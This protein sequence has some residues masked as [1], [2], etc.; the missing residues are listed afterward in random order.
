MLLIIKLMM[1][2]LFELLITNNELTHLIDQTLFPEHLLGT[3]IHFMFINKYKYRKWN[4]SSTE[5]VE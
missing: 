5:S 3:Q 2:Q 1:V 4:A